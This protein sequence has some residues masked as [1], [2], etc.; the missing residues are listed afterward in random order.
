MGNQSYRPPKASDVQAQHQSQPR[1]PKGFATRQLGHYAPDGDLEN[2][3]RVI[4]DV[5]KLDRTM[6]DVYNDG[7]YNPNLDIVASSSVT[8]IPQ[9]AYNVGTLRQNAA[10][11]SVSEVNSPQTISPQDSL[12]DFADGD[13]TKNFTLFP[14]AE[15]SRFGGMN[16]LTDEEVSLGQCESSTPQYLVDDEAIGSAHYLSPG[17]SGVY[18]LH[19]LSAFGAQQHLQPTITF[20]GRGNASNASRTSRGRLG[21]KHKEKV[22]DRLEA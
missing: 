20:E 4:P 19:N 3:R 18:G 21:K 11:R 15:S 17:T 22:I 7:L 9:G 14:R 16:Q 13:C 8:S 6:T 12:L 5:P 2:R 10:P 1:T